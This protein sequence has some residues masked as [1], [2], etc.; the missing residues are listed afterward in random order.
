MNKKLLIILKIFAIISIITA[1]VKIILL[2][3]NW[4]NF[5]IA[6]NFY[7]IVLN[8]M[9]IFASILLLK[10]YRLSIIIYAVLIVVNT[11]VFYGFPPSIVGIEIYFRPWAISMFVLSKVLFIGLAI[12]CWKLF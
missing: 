3:I 10:G 4:P 12:A 8:I 6:R 9:T 7:N 5:T 11:I 1:A 2:P